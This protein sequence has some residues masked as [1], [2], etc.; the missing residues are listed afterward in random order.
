MRIERVLV[1]LSARSVQ[2][3]LSLLLAWLLASLPV[4]ADTWSHEGGT[5]TL[6]QMPERVVALNWAAAEALLLLDVTP[7]GVADQALYSYWVREPEMPEDMQE[8]GARSVPSM[9]AIAQL[10][11]DLIVTSSQ[12]APAISQLERIAPTY[13]ISVYDNDANPW[14]RAREMLLTLGEI[15]GREDRARAVLEELD[16]ELRQLRRSL[17][18][19]GLAD[20]RVAVVSFLDD[21][22]VRINAP[23][24]LIQAAIERLGLRNAW[25]QEGNFWGFS[26]VGLEAL[27]R[28]GEV[29]LVVLSPVTP[30]VAASLKDSPLWQALPAVRE[31]QVHQVDPVWA[32]G[33]VHAMRRM[34]R[35]LTRSLL[36]GGSDSVQ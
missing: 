9:E 31:E 4:R 21:R 6:E 8:L 18:D 20:E 33:G 1:R 5:L 14:S 24:G 3:A 27:A 17:A 16:A 32:Y 23:N 35:F 12:L 36:E 13:V 28:L 10:E 2:H 30:A 26:V 34:A 29:R 19:A 7:V 11:P 22:H 15:L 25:Q